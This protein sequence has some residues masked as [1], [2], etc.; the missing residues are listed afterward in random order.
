MQPTTTASARPP[1]RAVIA[2][3]SGSSPT[4]SLTWIGARTAVSSAQLDLGAPGNGHDASTADDADALPENEETTG[5]PPRIDDPD[6]VYMP[7]PGSRGR[8]YRRVSRAAAL[9]I[10]AGDAPPPSGWSR[11]RGSGGEE[12]GD[13]SS[14]RARALVKGV[15][16]AGKMVGRLAPPVVLGMCVMELLLLSSPASTWPLALAV[17]APIAR[18]HVVALDALFT[19]TLV[20]RAVPVWAK[21]QRFSTSSSSLTVAPAGIGPAAAT[22]IRPAKLVSLVFWTLAVLGNTLAFPLADDVDVSLPWSPA[23][24][25]WDGES[26]IA[27]WLALGPGTAA[28]V[29]AGTPTGAWWA[30]T[31]VRVVGV[32]VAWVAELVVL[33]LGGGGK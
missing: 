14:R 26:R 7:V 10:L 29:P 9:A 5:L 33:F 4:T 32:A 25:A 28:A 17:C 8:A 16:R 20:T 6:A 3:A 2:L 22:P 1:P 27:R 11:F 13:A 24:T 23:H 18:G 12:E 30:G 15:A 21:R 19:V 31:W